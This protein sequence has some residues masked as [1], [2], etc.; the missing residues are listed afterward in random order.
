MVKAQTPG[1]AVSDSFKCPATDKEAVEERS[2]GGAW[3]IMVFYIF[4]VV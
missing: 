4:Y 2:L 1:Q 3:K